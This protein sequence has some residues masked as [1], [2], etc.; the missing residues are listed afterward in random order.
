M[1]Y[2]KEEWKIDTSGDSTAI[3]SVRN[4]RKCYIAQHLYD[5]ENEPCP[6]EFL[7]NAHLIAKAPRM[8]EL[9]EHLLNIPFDTD[10]EN[11]DEVSSVLD[12]ANEIYRELNKC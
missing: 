4:G 1:D 7:A 5:E 10:D 9:L 8:Y 11:F 2:T 3:T 6:V 12:E